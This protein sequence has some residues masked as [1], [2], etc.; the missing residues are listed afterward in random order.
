MNCKTR[1]SSCG[2]TIPKIDN[3]GG[4]SSYHNDIFASDRYANLAADGRF[5]VKSVKL[6]GDGAL[7]SRGAALLDDYSD[8]PGWRGFLLTPEK[9]WRPLIKAWY[10]GVRASTSNHCSSLMT[11]AGMASRM[12]RCPAL[13]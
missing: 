7:G 11:I 9:V 12:S 4:P 8:R 3:A 2:D 1:E 10:D 13:N 5:N 6:F